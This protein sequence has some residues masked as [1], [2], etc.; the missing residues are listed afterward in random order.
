MNRLTSNVKVS[1][2]HLPQPL[3]LFLYIKLSPLIRTAFLSFF[4]LRP[5]HLSLQASH[6]L[7]QS[8]N[9]KY[10]TIIREPRIIKYA[11]F[12][13]RHINVQKDKL[14]TKI[15]QVPTPH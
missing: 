4:L 2:Q 8:K 7:V 6:P 11:I 14:L 15:T 3:P 1:I 5:G 10:L 9:K 13:S 12:Q